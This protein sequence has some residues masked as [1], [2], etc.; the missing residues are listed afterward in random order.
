MLTGRRCGA[1]PGA[2]QVRLG[3]MSPMS[4]S[5]TP[6]RPRQATMSAGLAVGGSLFLLLTVFETLGRMHTVQ[7]REQVSEA[8][9]SGSVDA[10]GISVD[11]ALALMRGA[12][13]VAAVCAAVALVAGVFCFQRHRGA[14]G[15][16]PGHRHQRSA[17]VAASGSTRHSTR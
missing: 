4:E 10:L 6:A 14:R 7:M 17:A 3:K 13:S 16:D 11:Q 2:R 5:R 12:L 15:D 9:S 8:L 1:R